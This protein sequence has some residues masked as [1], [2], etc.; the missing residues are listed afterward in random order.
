M[1]LR[2]LMEIHREHEVTVD[3]KIMLRQQIQGLQKGTCVPHRFFFREDPNPQPKSRTIPDEVNDL[4]GKM[5][6][7]DCCFIYSGRHR[8]LQL[9][10]KNRLAADRDQY[11]RQVPK[12]GR[13][14][15]PSAT[16]NYDKVIN[17]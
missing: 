4:I 16:R 1:P 10:L 9:V 2:D 11:L 13:Q 15:D 5:P 6:S 3:D 17:Q 7:E 8:Q 14:T 12:N